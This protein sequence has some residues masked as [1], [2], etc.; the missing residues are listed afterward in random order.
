MGA[1]EEGLWTGTLIFL[2]TA[3]VTAGILGQYV[4]ART[5]DR[6]QASDNRM[7]TFGLTF[8]GAFCMWVLWICT[9]MH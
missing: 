2:G 5:K 4:F 3:V 7:M 6:S 1:K 9:Y 8:L